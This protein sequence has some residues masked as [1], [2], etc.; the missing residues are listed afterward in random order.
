V[1]KRE[2]TDAEVLA[3]GN[4]ASAAITA[5]QKAVGARASHSPV[6]DAIARL[7]RIAEDAK[8]PRRQRRGD[9][10]PIVA[11]AAISR[12]WSTDPPPNQ[13]EVIEIIG[14]IR[15]APLSYSAI[16]LADRD[17]G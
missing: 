7:K 10:E 12:V 2:Y 6:K 4:D 3:A 17:A 1:R 9:V 11:F 5:Y 14:G 13:E 8:R 15:N 16:V